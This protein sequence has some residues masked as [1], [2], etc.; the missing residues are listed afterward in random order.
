MIR[1]QKDEKI[2]EVDARPSDAISLAMHYDPPLPIFV[3]GDVLQE[4]S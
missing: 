1:L 3:E 4:A 2:I